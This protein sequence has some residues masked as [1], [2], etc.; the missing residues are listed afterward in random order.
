M[1]AIVMQ[2]P[3]STD[4]LQATTLPLPTLSLP[5]QV[6]IR[7]H[8]ASINPVDTKLRARGS[9]FPDRTPTILGCDGAGVI[10]A[11]GDAVDRFKVG[12]EVYFCHGGIGDEPGNYAEYTVAHEDLIAHKPRTLDFIQAAAVPLA[13]ITAWESLYDRTATG[14][15]DTVLIH[16]GA[17]GVGH[18]AI[19]LARLR[20]ARIITT[21]SSDEKAALARSLGAEQCIDYRR[22]DFVAAVNDWTAGT[23]VD[24]AFDTVGGQTFQHSFGCVKYYGDLVTLLQPGADCDWKEARLRNLR[25][26]QEL[27]L[28]P[29]VRHLHHWRQHQASILHQAATLFDQGKL[30]VEVS[31]VLALSQAAEAHRLIEQG[32]VTGKIVLRI[33]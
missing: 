31:H 17:G 24:I 10:E 16:A 27:M 8:A 30:R 15:G 1:R 3:G 6:L 13:L 5:N 25:I 12:D 28:T 18:L 32:G 23:G 4:A 14:E 20:G 26:T 21:V 7:L 9:Y 19:Q 11:I 22:Q 33:D 2:Q 29:M